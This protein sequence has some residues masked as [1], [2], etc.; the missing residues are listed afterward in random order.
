MSAQAYD[1]AFYAGKSSSGPSLYP[2]LLPGLCSQ[3]LHLPRCKWLVGAEP[4][5][6][7]CDWFPRR[8]HQRMPE[9]SKE[10]A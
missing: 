1:V 9:I 6:A 2:A 5:W 3:C 4:W 10:A 7:D 8:F